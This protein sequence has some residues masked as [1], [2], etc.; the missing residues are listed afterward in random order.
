MRS[1]LAGAR[2]LF[3]IASQGLIGPSPC[4]EPTAWL[5]LQSLIALN[6]LIIVARLLN[7]FKFILIVKEPIQWLQ[8]KLDLEEGSLPQDNEDALAAVESSSV[9]LK[10]SPVKPPQKSR[11]RK[12]DGTPTSLSRPSSVASPSTKALY[13]A[14]FSTIKEVEGLTRDTSDETRGFAVEYMKATLRGSPEH[15]AAMLGS[16][17]AITH[18]I[19]PKLKDQPTEFLDEYLNPMLAIWDLRSNAND[20]PSGQPSSVCFQDD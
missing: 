17:F 7:T 13:K 2:S 14:V 19:L 20:D 3:R 1:T 12:R 5:L 11:K 16:F 18:A 9:T 10:I 4:L 15:A 8:Q 6:P